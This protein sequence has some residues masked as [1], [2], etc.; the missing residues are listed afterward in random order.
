MV[1]DHRSVLAAAHREFVRARVH[2]GDQHVFVIDA[3]EEVRRC[4][5]REHPHVIHG[6]EDSV[7][8]QRDLSRVVVDGRRRTASHDGDLTCDRVVQNDHFL[9]VDADQRSDWEQ[10]FI[11]DEERRARQAEVARRQV[12]RRWGRERAVERCRQNLEH[13]QCIGERSDRSPRQQ[14]DT[15]GH[16]QCSCRAGQRRDCRDQHFLAADAD[17][18]VRGETSAIFHVKCESRRSRRRCGN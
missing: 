11:G 6:Q 14:M 10:R 3:D 18:A 1:R 7:V 5:S 2:C 9:A 8:E 17:D 12:G 16:G 4:R 15:P 13:T